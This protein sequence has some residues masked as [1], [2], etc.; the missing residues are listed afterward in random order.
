MEFAEVFWGWGS[1]SNYSP[2]SFF[3][4]SIIGLHAILHCSYCPDKAFG[5]TG[6]KEGMKTK[7]ENHF[8]IS[9][10]FFFF[11]KFF[12]AKWVQFCFLEGWYLCDI[13]FPEPRTARVQRLHN[14]F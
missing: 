5:T 8:I 9:Q 3:M 12:P 10:N 4:L 11:L 14:P 7:D 13:T 1:H 2:I 6:D